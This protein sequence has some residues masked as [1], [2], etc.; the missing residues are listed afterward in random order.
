[1]IEDGEHVSLL[2]IVWPADEKERWRYDRKQKCILGSISN[3]Y[4]VM[5][6]VYYRQPGSRLVKKLRIECPYIKKLNKNI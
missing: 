6:K 5:I 1:M 4:C 3:E 2:M